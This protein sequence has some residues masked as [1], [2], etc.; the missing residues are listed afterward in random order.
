MILVT[1]ATGFLGTHLLQKLS[2]QNIPVRALYHKNLPASDFGKQIDWQQCNLLDTVEIEAAMNGIQ[3]VVHCAAIVSFDAR[4]SKEMIDQ[5]E[6]ITANIVNAAIIANVEKFVHISSIAALGRSIPID[7]NHDK[8]F[9]DEETPWIESKQNS[10]YAESK[11]HAELEVWRGMAEG[12]N[13]IILNP[14][15]ILGEGDWNKGSAQLMQIVAKEFPWF[16]EGI[17]GW[18]DVEDVVNAIL[19]SLNTN[20]NNERFV[21]N[22]GNYA[23]KDIFTQMA[24]A[25]NKKP[26]HKKA[27]KWMTELVWRMELLKSRLA[28]KEP[29]I[30]RASAR[31]AQT[32]C[33]YN[34]EKFLKQFPEF[35]YT[36]IETTIKRMAEA[37]KN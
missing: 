4:K 37:Y 13:A 22:N 18:V 30:T 27:N 3:K 17:N 34:N 19:L 23:Y 24:L 12:L 32:Q 36:P 35:Q 1:G 26:P 29:T 21:I 10:A 16:T 20:I 7:E 15:V 2:Q 11:Y 25:L 8:L 31:T 33:F 14:S 6:A 28:G 9:I 5:N